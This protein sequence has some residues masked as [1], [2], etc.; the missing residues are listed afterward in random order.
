[1]SIVTLVVKIAAKPA[2]VETA[3]CELLKLVAPTRREA[4]CL[5]YHLHQDNADPAQ[6]VFFERWESPAQLQQHMQSAHFKHFQTA[7][8]DS[9]AT[10]A[11]QE[12]T[13][14]E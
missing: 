4:G 9:I 6:F 1:M 12:L 11:V 10:V 14:L 5:D 13:R 7:S 2:C 8:A 3:K